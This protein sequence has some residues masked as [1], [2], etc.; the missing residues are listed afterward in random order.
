MPD[1]KPPRLEGDER[2]TL[3]A[4]LQ[5]QRASLVRKVRGVGEDAARRTFVASG[6]SLLWLV[7]HLA[8]AESLWVLRRFAGERDGIP[9]DA[10]APD[11]TVEGAIGRYQETWR[12]VDAV[13]A[14]ASLDATCRD[15]GDEAPVNLRWVL[16]HLL[17]E[18]ARHA[19]HADV[20][21]ELIDGQ[22]GR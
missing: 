20:I 3:H 16:A 21:R 14:A 7:T 6:T 15:V 5:Y 4:L 18:T 2:A 1:Q 19:G 17:E 11:E 13:V 22:T 10:V 12:R 8:R 9:D